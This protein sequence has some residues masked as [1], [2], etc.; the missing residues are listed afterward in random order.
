MLFPK[1]SFP[2]PRYPTIFWSY[3]FRV[4]VRLYLH[5]AAY[6]GLRFFQGKRNVVVQRQQ[7]AAPFSNKESGDR[8][9]RNAEALEHIQ[10]QANEVGRSQLDRVG[11]SDAGDD[12]LRV[13][14][15]GKVHQ[16]LADA[17]LSLSKG[18]STRKA[19]MRGSA[20]NDLPQLQAAETL[21]LLILPFPEYTENIR[22]YSRFV[23]I[24]R[25][26]LDNR[27]LLILIIR[28]FDLSWISSELKHGKPP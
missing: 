11:V 6:R 10:G 8:G 1:H 25:I 3:Q 7:P 17:V 14:L 4:A 16:L 22:I 21:Q 26:I 19:E 18:F 27:S 9:R 28:S 15:A 24:C 2:D 12:F 13:M 20:L 23:V 5:S